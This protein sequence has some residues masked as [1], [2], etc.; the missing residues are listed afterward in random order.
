MSQWTSGHGHWNA[1]VARHRGDLDAR[2]GG[3]AWVV[4]YYKFQ[5]SRDGFSGPG[6]TWTE[7]AAALDNGI[8]DYF[9]LLRR[10]R[11][12]LCPAGDVWEGGCVV[13]ALEMGSVPVVED[14]ARYKGCEDPAAFY[15]A[16]APARDHAWRA[17][18]DFRLRGVGA[19][20]IR[21]RWLRRSSPP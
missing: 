15:S 20:W 9:D 16:P 4:D 11:L 7:S 8:G 1:T 19:R 3:D 6:Y 2:F 14:A 18:P 12:T 10:S 17:T 13:Q 21:A 5:I